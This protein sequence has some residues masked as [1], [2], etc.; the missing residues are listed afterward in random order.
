[1]LETRTDTSQERS[2]LN[3]R[4]MNFCSSP[5]IAQFLWFAIGK[6]PSVQTHKKKSSSEIPSLKM[7]SGWGRSSRYEQRRSCL[8]WEVSWE[9][10]LVKLVN[11]QIRW[12]FYSAIVYNRNLIRALAMDRT[13]YYAVA[14]FCLSRNFRKICPAIVIYGLIMRQTFLG[15]GI[16]WWPPVNSLRSYRTSI[17]NLYC[18]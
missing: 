11:C 14:H 17:A 9:L 13:G 4:K 12:Q 5:I 2:N 18:S 8:F 3:L 16:Q 6:E 10:E 1:M 15:R 7:H